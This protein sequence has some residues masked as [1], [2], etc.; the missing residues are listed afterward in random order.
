[1]GLMVIRNCIAFVWLRKSYQ[2]LTQQR[3]LVKRLKKFLMS[4]ILTNIV[5]AAVTDNARTMI[6][7]INGIGFLHF[8]CMG[9]TLQLG[10]LKT[11]DIGPVKAAL[12]H[13]SNI[14]SHFDR[15]SKATYSLTEKQHLLGLKPHMLKSSCVT[16]WGSTYKMLARFMEQQQAV[17]LEDGGDCVLIPSSTEFAVIEQLVDILK[18]FNDATEILSGDL[19]PTLGI[20]QPI[21][22]RFLSEVLT[23]KPEDRDVVKKLKMQ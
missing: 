6:N 14:V 19:Y 22:Y 3:I 4:G 10:I 7:A 23:S 5:V 9:H 18:P 1:M 2:L 15:S 21:S 16:R 20:V 17:L 11:F 13:I 8:P 12:A